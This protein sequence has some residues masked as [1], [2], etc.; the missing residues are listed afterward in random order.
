MRPSH[1]EDVLVARLA[2]LARRR[3]EL[4]N[5]LQELCERDLPETNRQLLSKVVGSLG[6]RE[7]LIASLKLIDDAKPTPVPQGVWNQLESAFV[8]ERTNGLNPFDLTLHAQ[9]SNDVR[10]RLFRMA[11]EDGRRRK[12]A[13]TLLGKIELWRLQHG[14][15]TDEPRHPDLESGGSWPHLQT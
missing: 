8:E 11:R 15:P 1:R 7:A 14:R 12:S 6:T 9:S 2:E 5:R 3:P 4:A 10:V 13:F